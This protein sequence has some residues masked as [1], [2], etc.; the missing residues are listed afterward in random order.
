MYAAALFQTI[1]E[2]GEAILT[3]MDGVE[4]GEL[5]ASRLTRHEVDRQL[6]LLHYAVQAL[7][8]DLCQ[9]M[10]EVDWSGMKGVAQTLSLPS[11]TQRDQALLFATRSQVPALMMWLRV[12]REQHPDWF[13]QRWQASR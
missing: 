12:Y 7:P 4:D 3:L 8:T 13:E 1:N 5:L 10:P 2:C 6:K 9:A 11:S